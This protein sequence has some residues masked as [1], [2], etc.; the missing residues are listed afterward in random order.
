VTVAEA[1]SRGE[2]IR[3]EGDA[4]R[5]KIYA[6]AYN[7]DRD[8]FGFYRSMQAYEHSMKRGD[9]TFLIAPDSDFMR[10]FNDSSGKPLAAPKQ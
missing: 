2:Q 9:T 1:Q 10:Y 5:N 7:Q 3:G 8:F 4:T 6:D